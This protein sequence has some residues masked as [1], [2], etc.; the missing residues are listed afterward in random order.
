MTSCDVYHYQGLSSPRSIRL[1]VLHRDANPSVGQGLRCDLVEASVDS[2]PSYLALSYTWGGEKPSEP[3]TIQTG[4]P[5]RTSAGF[6]DT[7]RPGATRLL[8]TPNCAMALSLLQRSMKRMFRTRRQISV[9]VDGICIDQSNTEERST[10][11]AMMAKIYNRAKRVVVWLGEHYAPES[12][13]SLAVSKPLSILPR[14]EYDHNNHGQRFKRY[15][16]KMALKVCD[17][18]TLHR[19]RLAPYWTRVWTLQEFAHKSAA[20]LCCDSRLLLFANLAHLLAVASKDETMPTQQGLDLH[21]NLYEWQATTDRPF[22]AATNQ[23]RRVLSMKAS[24]P[25]DKIYAL[26]ALSP[27]VLGKMRVDYQQPIGEVFQEA[28]RLMVEEEDSLRVL[29]FSNREKTTAGVPWDTL[30]SWTVDFATEDAEMRGSHKYYYKSLCA[31]SGGSRPVFAFSRDGR[32]VHLRGV[33]VGRVTSPVSDIF[34]ASS[35]CMEGTGCVSDD[36]IKGEKEKEPGQTFQHDCQSPYLDVLGNFM[37]DVACRNEPGCKVDKMGSSLC[38]LLWWIIQGPKKSEWSSS[39]PSSSCRV[40]LRV[41]RLFFTSDQIA[42]FAVT[43]VRE[44]DI[45]CLIA[46]LDHPFI[47]RPRKDDYGRYALVRPTVFSGAMS[48]EMWPANDDGLEDFEVV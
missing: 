39:T 48:G 13:G 24:E 31:A 35:K 44:G 26:R 14:I 12:W 40:A 10:Q 5:E 11:V 7:S 17:E 25:R 47:L 29:Y 38:R 3:L 28:T 6:T 19:L 4:L 8:I 34:P 46:G 45:V 36:K 30:P 32:S 42:G 9:W 33:R 21:V 43:S 1:V 27:G 2:P 16:A 20:I 41:G 37:K 15:T 18:A 23:L 22:R